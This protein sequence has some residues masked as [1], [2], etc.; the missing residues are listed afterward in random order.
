MPDKDNLGFAIGNLSREIK[1]TINSA[2]RKDYID[3]LTGTHGYILGFIRDNENHD[4]YQRD[5][6]R[7]FRICRSTAT[8]ILQLMEKKKL[9]YRESV[10]SDGRLKK[11]VLT[12]RAR[13]ISNEIDFQIECCEK[14]L[15]RDFTDEEIDE[16]MRLIKKMRCNLEYFRSGKTN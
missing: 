1:L 7:E 8:K 14:A 6:E 13:E 3:E 4:L 11:I 16:M 2:V 15:V 5:I 9:L 12:D 10:S